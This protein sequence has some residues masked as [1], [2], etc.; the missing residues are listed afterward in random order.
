[1][2]TRWAGWRRTE[3]NAREFA[4]SGFC[5]FDRGCRVMHNPVASISNL[6]GVPVPRQLSRPWPEPAAPACASNPIA[7]PAATL[8]PGDHRHTLGP[9]PES[10]PASPDARASRDRSGST[11][12]APAFG[13]PAALAAGRSRT[14]HASFLARCSRHRQHHR[15]LDGECQELRHCGQHARGFAAACTTESLRL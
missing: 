5:Y 11:P 1:M 3:E 6:T 9:C 2:L 4:C 7:V 10:L 12:D 14:R 13:D 8:G 15:V